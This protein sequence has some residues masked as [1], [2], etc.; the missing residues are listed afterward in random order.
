MV[1]SFRYGWSER[2]ARITFLA[3]FCLS[4][5]QCG[6]GSAAPTAPPPSPAPVISHF[7]ASPGLLTAGGSCILEWSVSGATTLSIDPSVGA[8]S[9]TTAQVM[10]TTTITYTLTATGAGGIA[11]AQTTVTVV[12]LPAITSF[13][14]SPT[15]VATSGAS[16]LT[17]TFTGGTGLVDHGIGTVS[18]GM[19]V[20]TGALAG[21][22]N[23]KLTVT[24][25][26]G[27]QVTAT[28]AVTVG[29]A[30]VITGFTAAKA[31]ITAGSSTTLTPT[32]VNAT[33]ASV[34]QG[35]GAVTSG[36][37]FTVSP[38][39]T[40]Q[41]T[42]TAEGIGGPVTLTLTVVVVPLGSI[43]AFTVSPAPVRFS[44]SG[45]LTATFSGGAGS[46][47]HGLGAVSSGIPVATGL[48]WADTTYVL[49]VTNE[50]G[51]SVTRSLTV[52]ILLLAPTAMTYPTLGSAFTVGSDIGMHFPSY[53]GDSP[54]DWEISP[55][56]PAGFWFDTESGMIIGTP[57]AAAP[58]TTYT[59][60]ARNTA[61]STSCQI[62]FAVKDIPPLITY[63]ASHTFTMGEAITKVTPSSTGGVVVTW[64]ILPTL[65]T[66]LAFSTLDGSISGTPT[67]VSASQTYAVTATNSGGTHQASFSVT[68]NP[69]APTILTQPANLTVDI[70]ATPTFTVTVNG[71]G[72]LTY[73][74]SKNGTPIVGA[75][76]SSYTTPALTYADNGA[77]F[78]VVASDTYGGSV[79]ST[80]GVLTVRP[81][82]STW[83]AAH[84]TV[85]AAIK[86]QFQYPAGGNAYTP[87]G[88]ADMIAW[89]NWS[90]AQKDDLDA[91]YL[92][93]RA[94]LLQSPKTPITMPYRGV[95]DAPTNWYSPQSDG[96]IAM[97]WTSPTDMW[98]LYIAH[99]GFSLALETTGSVPWSLTTYDAESLRYLL[100]SSTMGWK[101]PY[102]PVSFSLGTYGGANLPALRADNR[103]KTPFAHPMWIYQWMTQAG[104]PA[105]TRLN[106]IGGVLD[107]M[108]HNMSHFYGTDDFGTCNA[109]WQYRGYPPIS[110]IINGTTDVNVSQFAHWTLG[111]HGSVGFLN[112]T[113][114]ALNIPVQ[115]IWVGGHELACFLTERMYLDHGD[116]P[117]NAVVRVTY[118]SS[119]ILNV[120]IDEATYKA[121]FTSDLTVNLNAPSAAVMANI[122]KAAADFK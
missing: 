97:Q 28:A 120:L 62:T 98:N 29:S 24:N 4:L 112:A 46:I 39:T 31:T 76:G 111:C 9:G 23:F 22:T 12:P 56:L 20:S 15:T 1:R 89:T 25:A 11:T 32:F 84:P 105:D 75:T 104:I 50:A 53:S 70:G 93:A 100:D 66:G 52:N 26:V 34:D 19:P 77:T 110:R 57:A 87:P 59:V 18:S 10:P 30:V 35:V 8:V 92:D 47:D 60:T 69:P 103:P 40:T 85:A 116:D 44:T 119:P 65:P 95:S 74:W 3:L 43:A 113:L 5:I 80:A 27:A 101:L 14:A 63:G 51:D 118:P 2:A 41:Y 91:A 45:Q 42:L 109:V 108:R 71:T 122:G 114:R 48:L 90:Q 54:D 37:P 73:Q 96:G 64:S 16:Q 121:R 115:P 55:A 68:V 6:G 99:I 86:W 17:A 82:L 58:T 106:S 88:D 107:W 67:V 83:L 21:S 36:L 61:G 94:W 102:G 13:A 38:A 117:Y 79:T 81:A 7:T 78:T 72:A 33:R 49:T